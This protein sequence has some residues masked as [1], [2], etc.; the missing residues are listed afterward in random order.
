[1]PVMDGKRLGE[2]IKQAPE[3][4]K[5]ILMMLSSAGSQQ[6]NAQLQEIGF[7]AHLLKPLPRHQLQ[8]TLLTLRN[9]FIH[10]QESLKFITMVE[11]NQFQVKSPTQNFPN[12]PVL[13][14]EDNEVN[15]M[16]AVNMLEELGCQVTLAVNGFQA[17]EK[18]KEA[19]FSV[20]F[21]DVQMPEMDGLEA[22]RYIRA[23]EAQKK[24]SAAS[25]QLIVAMTASAMQG[26]A[27]RCLATGMDDYIAKP[28]SLDCII[29][30]LDKYCSSY[31][32]QAHSLGLKPSYLIS[33]SL[34]SSSKKGGK[35]NMRIGGKKINVLLVED[36][37]VGCM[38]ATHM[39]EKLGCTVETA[40]NGK[41]AI[42]KCA[43]NNYDIILMDIQMPVMDGVEATKQ[44]RKNYGERTPIVAVTANTQAVDIKHYLSVGMND[45]LGKP[46]KIGQVRAV[47]EKYISSLKKE[48][49]QKKDRSVVHQ[50]E[51]V[52]CHSIEQSQESLSSENKGLENKESEKK[53]GS[54]DLAIFDVE[55]AKRIAIGNLNIFKKIVDKFTE[56]TPTQLEKLKTAVREENQI[57]AK[58]SAH[59]IKG[60]ARS[61][62]ALRLG[63]VA[64]R[65]EQ[66]AEQ[67]E[68]AEINALFN[69]MVDEFALLQSLWKD[70]EWEALF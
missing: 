39:L 20:V 3:I 4:E 68:L 54:N 53:N 29:D 58:R 38:V 36:N 44:I 25:R 22:T 6:E 65:A 43:H 59:S 19:H 35:E 50:E 61:V 10:P 15:S 31:Q 66:I 33:S 30:I 46:V 63:D 27:E 37:P 70:T 55:Q 2:L 14:V 69:I 40:E 67:G 41:Q 52:I 42:E 64:F 11:V 13:L 24:V 23:S 17:L 28:I 45:C 9:S 7:S 21:M 60:S 49:T 56:D 32:T 16:V 57:E 18:L 1:M 5:T 62:G 8:Q 34:S 48:E 26:D 47:V 51:S 12:L